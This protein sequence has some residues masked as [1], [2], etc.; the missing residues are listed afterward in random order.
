MC[1]NNLSGWI[2]DDGFK[3]RVNACS[4]Y[5]RGFNVCSDKLIIRLILQEM[6]TNVRNGKECAGICFR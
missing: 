3:V 2:F 1:K 4:R 6:H 5:S